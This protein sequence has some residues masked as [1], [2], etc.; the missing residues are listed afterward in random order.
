MATSGSFSNDHSDHIL[1]GEIS[2]QP[3]RLM[4]DECNELFGESLARSSAVHKHPHKHPLPLEVLH[5]MEEYHHRFNGWCTFLGVFAAD[6]AALDSRLR[7]HA[8]LQD[9]VIRMLDMLRQNLFLVAIHELPS[10]NGD[11]VNP[12][13]PFTIY[14]VLTGIK[15]ATIRLNK[16]GIVIR[17]SSRSTITARARRFAS[18][19]SER[20]RLPEFEDR[21]YLAL[22]YL[23]PNAPE[24][25][26]QQLFD[27]MIDRY[28]KL[29]YE[30][31]RTKGSYASGK[32]AAQ[33][34]SAVNS[35][36]KEN[37][38]DKAPD[39]R[40]LV[41]HKEGGDEAHE[42]YR[43]A[44]IVIPA[45]SIDTARLPPNLEQAAA[46][47]IRGSKPPKT[48]TRRND[49]ALE[50]DLPV[51]E[52]GKDHTVCEWCHEVIDRSV[53]HATRN[54]WSDHGRRH[55]R[56][57]LQ[58]YVCVAE[59][60]RELRPSFASSRE[61][62]THM[63]SNHT[64][65]WS[66]KLHN[67]LDWICTARHENSSVYAF[68][69]KEELLN[70]IRLHQCKTWAC[71]GK[72]EG[73][74]IYAFDSKDRLLR[75][76]AD[77]QCN[78]END[79]E[80]SN[81]EHSECLAR[82]ARQALSCPLCLFSMEEKPLNDEN[83]ADK[84]DDEDTVTSW[85]MGSH[86]AEHLH[87]LMIVSLKII[88]T[89]QAPQ[90]RGG[91][92]DQNQSSGPSATSTGSAADMIQRRLDDLPES[93]QGSIDWSRWY[94]EAISK[95]GTQEEFVSTADSGINVP[96]LYSDQ[97]NAAT[98]R[99][100]TR[101]KKPECTEDVFEQEEVLAA[102]GAM[103]LTM[104]DE[105]KGEVQASHSLATLGQDKIV[106]ATSK[107]K[108]DT[109]ILRDETGRDFS[110]R[111]ELSWAAENGHEGT[112]KLLLDTGKVDVD[113]KDNNGR[114]PL[115]LAAE[116]GHEA[117][118]KLLLDTGK[119][120]IDSKDND[121]RT[122]LSFAAVNGHDAVVKL[123]LNT[124]KVD[125]HSKDNEGQTPLSL[126][127][128]NGHDAVVKLLLDTGEVEVDSRDKDGRTPLS[129]AAENGHEAIVKLLLNTGKV[130]VHSRSMDGRTALSIAAANGHDAIAK[131][132]LET[133]EVDV[134]SND[135]D[136]RTPL[137][138][139]AENG[140]T[141]II[142]LLLDTG[143]VD[144]D[145]KDKDGRTP[146]S[147]AAEN[148]HERA[149]HLLLDTGKVDV[150]SKDDDGRTPLSRAAE[151][152]HERAVHLLLDTGKVDVDSKDNN[153]RN[154]L[155]LAAENGHEAVVKLLLDTGKVDIDS[156]DNDGRTPLSRAAENGHERAVH[157]LLDT[158]KVDVDS[159][160]DDG[161]TPLSRAA[162][163]GHE[164][165]VHLL[166]GSGKVDVDSKDS[167]GRT[168]LSLAAAN[169]HE[170]AVHLL[171][172]TGKV[173]VD[174]RDNDG[175][176]PLSRAA[177][178]GQ[179][180]I[181]KLLL[182]TAE[183]NVNSRDS[184]GRTPLSWAAAN[185][186]ETTMKLLLQTAWI[187]A[188]LMDND[189]RTPLQYA[190]RGGKEAVVKL[191]L[192]TV[193][194][195]VNMQDK[196]VHLGSDMPRRRPVR[197]YDQKK[198]WVPVRYPKPHGKLIF[199]GSIL[200]DPE[201][202]ETSLN[203]ITGAAETLK[204]DVLDDSAAVRRQIHSELSTNAD[205]IL[206]AVPPSS[207]LFS[208]G[209]RVEGRSSD[210]VNTTVEAMN[211]SAKI[212]IPDMS[213]MDKAFKQ[214]EISTYLESSLWQKSLFMI[215]GVATAEDLGLAENWTHENTVIGSANVSLQKSVIGFAGEPS[216]GIV[217]GHNLRI[218][219]K[220]TIDFAYRVREFDFK[221]YRPGN[222][223]KAKGDWS[224]GA[225][226]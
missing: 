158:G 204:K 40:A 89:M 166:L 53:L 173:D 172:D 138:L 71:T 83:M 98:V 215:V 26:R 119:V 164:R 17:S 144:V 93:V 208:A 218:K 109:I 43:E 104:Q 195:E 200:T 223:I 140:Q 139:A 23:Y 5:A 135:S 34:Q 225:M 92:D 171:L 46:P 102:N 209:L 65:S 205:G 87:H 178:N 1:D 13:P 94:E 37:I 78:G 29:R 52:E 57:D 18:Q 10:A 77:H 30:D 143:K 130:D 150:D 210:E 145:S 8:S 213:Y 73:N 125:V 38:P 100:S 157:L 126:A 170:R 122:P 72:H 224:K 20:I 9:M 160:D 86:I 116:N 132:L 51:F 75:H 123:L 99:L 3:I 25:L 68:S 107:I 124:G 110:G 203:H 147:R 159:K 11:V 67:R 185:G 15:E 117:V 96:S 108:S 19:Y 199:L 47:S 152:G 186:H 120:D 114:N 45:S 220:Q 12:V 80:G 207:L 134:D 133:G 106:D 156:K 183:V 111:T 161:R 36:L 105:A 62:F 211:V 82:R 221:K 91:V 44:T 60:C 175:R 76:I 128:A 118:V 88:S 167:N 194:V 16:I 63:S 222:K 32:S 58:P 103:Q 184:N 212:F 174:S 127:A 201:D 188:N 28:A 69:Y 54:E 136:G 61:W 70:H 33:D 2:E 59:D 214:P 35:N 27:S 179:E 148:G 206:K 4:A 74:S 79:L 90:D 154:P 190:V 64:D 181:V 226:F 151:N 193:R 97:E 85:V 55:Y 169:G 176:T 182:D 187:D 129:W 141:A 192:E 39:D 177:E 153:G 142:K 112:V 198:K 197:P 50:P 191:L 31:Y 216:H 146:L 24:T 149:V 101:S 121:G 14:E 180:M 189:G 219:T 137:S 41:P 7:R 42:D 115:S 84:A 165:A 66:S 155:S 56:R 163:N 168:P 21:A 22:H 131:L 162:E 81:L 6:I 202:P 95:P 113:S 49:R 48:L 196:D 217:A